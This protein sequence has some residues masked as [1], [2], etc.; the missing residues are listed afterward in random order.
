[1]IMGMGRVWSWNL[2]GLWGFPWSKGFNRKSSDHYIPGQS[3][4]SLMCAGDWVSLKCYVYD[5]KR[6]TAGYGSSV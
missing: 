2:L 4:K 6:G 1:M 5:G 3:I